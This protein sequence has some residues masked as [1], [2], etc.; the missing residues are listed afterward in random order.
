MKIHIYEKFPENIDYTYGDICSF[1]DYDLEHVSG[2]DEVYY[3]YAQGS[4]EG[5][6]QFIGRMKG[7]WYMHSC[8]HCSCYGPLEHIELGESNAYDSLNELEKA[9][10]K[11][12]M[13]EVSPLISM[14]RENESCCVETYAQRMEREIRKAYSWIRKHNST[15]P[16]EVLDL[17]KDAA[18]EKVKS[19]EGFIASSA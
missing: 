5:M 10:S 2:F 6:G 12:L 19:E 15:I 7:K 3:W 1:S 8:G 18:I 9:C 4:Y 13:D 17:M 14:A 16:D 11:G